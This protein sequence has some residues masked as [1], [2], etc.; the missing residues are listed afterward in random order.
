[1]VKTENRI[2]QIDMARGIAIILVIIG[3][4]ISDSNVMFNK[5][6]LSFH[7]PLFFVIS[8]MCFSPQKSLFG[9]L[10][11][12]KKQIKKLLLPQMILGLIDIIY[13]FILYLFHIENSIKNPLLSV[14]GWWFLL[15]AFFL[16][17][18]IEI[19]KRIDLLSSN[20]KLIIIF[21]IDIVLCFVLLIFKWPYE[22]YYILYINV[23]PFAMAYYFAGIAFKTIYLKVLNK[24]SYRYLMF[25]VGILLC[26]LTFYIAQINTPVTMFNNNYGNVGLFICSAGMGIIAVF[27]FSI[28]LK[29]NIIEWCGNYS[30]IIY[31]LQFHVNMVLNF[32][33]RKIMVSFDT[34]IQTIV[35]VIFSIIVVLML[36]LFCSKYLWFLFGIRR[37]RI[38]QEKV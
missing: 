10:N 15:V 34:Y 29:N 11:F 33:V 7:M 31:V 12:V 18:I 38:N 2:K 36:S 16:S 8:G 9:F 37:G 32:F 21:M 26:L 25:I 22:G 4:A 6:I 3:H 14:F 20:I 19:L 24:N 27:L 13:H 1:M 30:I 5:F 28:V 35:V 17:L 23:I